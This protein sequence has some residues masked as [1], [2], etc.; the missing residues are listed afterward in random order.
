MSGIASAAR[1]IP[2]SVAP[3]A[4]CAS[5][6]SV[7]IWRISGSSATTRP[8]TR[9][10]GAA[11]GGMRQRNGPT[12]STCTAQHPAAA[13]ARGQARRAPA[14]PQETE[15]GDDKAD[16][17]GNLRNPEAAD[18]EAVEPQRLD[19]E[20]SDRVEADVA[21][22][23]RAGSIAQLGTQ[24]HHEGQEHGEVPDRLVKKRRMEVVELREAGRAMRRRDIELPRQ[25]RGTTERFLVEEVPPATDGL[26][27]RQRRP[28]HVE[29]ARDRQP[30]PPR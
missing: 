13:S 2:G 29:P 9:M 4:S 22:E 19:G 8:G 26:P 11:S 18:P 16:E 28:G 1:T 24:P 20:P 10:P 5:A 12:C 7:R 3:F 23:Q 25:I 14:R 15:P 6:A 21:E 17:A 30:P 27:D